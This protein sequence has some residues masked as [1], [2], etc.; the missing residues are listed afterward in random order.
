MI[1]SGKAINFHDSLI[2]VRLNPS[3]I[4][5]DEQWRPKKFH[6]IKNRALEE[7][8]IGAEE[9]SKLLQILKAQ[10]EKIFKESAYHALLAKKFLWNNHQ[11]A[12]AR[13]NLKKVITHNKLHWKSYFLYAVSFLPGKFLQ[14]GYQFLKSQPVNVKL[15]PYGQ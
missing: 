4:T 13:M 9:G 5:I 11:P 7:K 14:K 15:K 12:K 8:N 3:S 2:Q 10:N 6:L 1:N